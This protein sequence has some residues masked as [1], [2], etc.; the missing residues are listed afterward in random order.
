MVGRRRQNQGK[1]YGKKLRS[2]WAEKGRTN[3]GPGPIERRGHG[4][5]PS[6][7]KS[8]LP[9]KDMQKSYLIGCKNTGQGTPNLHFEHGTGKC[10]RTGINWLPT[11]QRARRGPT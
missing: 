1:K 2:G 7:E 10:H 5:K 3:N 6:R 11:C 4:R 8:R 9:E